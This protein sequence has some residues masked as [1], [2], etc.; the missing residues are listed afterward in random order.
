LDTDFV[1]VAWLKNNRIATKEFAVERDADDVVAIGVSLDKKDK[2]CV[3]RTL[4]DLVPGVAGLFSVEKSA[5]HLSL[6]S[7]ASF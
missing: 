7:G 2:R 6:V 5:E 4:I 3:F 1:L